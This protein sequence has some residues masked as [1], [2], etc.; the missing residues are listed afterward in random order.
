MDVAAQELSALLTASLLPVIHRNQVQWC[1]AEGVSDASPK[2]LEQV[3]QR[4][5]ETAAEASQLC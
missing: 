3:R 1:L 4:L 2:A 5:R